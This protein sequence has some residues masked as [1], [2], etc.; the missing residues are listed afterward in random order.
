MRANSLQARRQTLICI[1]TLAFLACAGCN[2]FKSDAEMARVFDRKRGDFDQLALIAEQGTPRDAQRQEYEAILGRIGIEKGSGARQD[3]PGAV[4]LYQE[5]TGGA[6]THICKG[7]VH[8]P[9]PLRPQ[10]PDLDG[11][12]TGIAFKPLAQNWYLFAD[13]D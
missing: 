4:F 13:Y 9:N 1:V 12:F 2:H 8:S 11:S 10:Q 7:Y 6:T 3:F 5:C